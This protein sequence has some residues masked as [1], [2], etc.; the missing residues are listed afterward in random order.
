MGTDGRTNGRTYLEE[1]IKSLR[2]CEA[3][4][5]SLDVGGHI[6]ILLIFDVQ[7]FG[8]MYQKVALTFC[9]LTYETVF[10]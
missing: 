7:H 6:Y 5:I 8:F 1:N 10:I 3:L 9:V 4:V 2:S